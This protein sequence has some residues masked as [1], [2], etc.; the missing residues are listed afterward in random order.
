MTDKGYELRWDLTAEV[1]VLTRVVRLWFAGGSP[2]LAVVTLR[3]WC[4]HNNDRW[5]AAGDLSRSWYQ[6][7]KW[8]VSGR[9]RPLSLPAVASC[10][11]LCGA[12]ASRSPLTSQESYK[13][14]QGHTAASLRLTTQ[15]D[16]GRLT[17][18][19]IRSEGSEN[20]CRKR[21]SR[22][23]AIRLKSNR[24]EF[25]GSRIQHWNQ[26]TTREVFIWLNWQT[27]GTY[28]GWC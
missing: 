8:L 18:L 22:I 17:S 21:G 11:A 20:F 5:D 12:V 23:Q 24:Y 6:L 25:Q 7:S 10:W 9:A 28:R 1:V 14:S 2:C 19:L 27:L 15:G 3:G 4:P 16:R 13:P 26:L